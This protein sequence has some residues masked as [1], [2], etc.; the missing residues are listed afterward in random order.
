[1]ET[2]EL[3]E[4]FPLFTVAE[5]ETLEWLLS[6]ADECEFSAGTTL[7][8]DGSWGTAV[9]FI[10]SGWLRMQRKHG[11][12]AIT[13][14]VLGRGDFIGDAAILD[15]PPRATEAIALTDV[16]TLGVSAQRFIQALFK[17]PQL[18]HK[19][20]QHVVRR[21]RQAHTLLSLRHQP[22]LVR[23][24][25]TIV[26]I[27][28]EYGTP[29]EEGMEIVNL[30]ARDWADLS[31]IGVD[32]VANLLAKWQGKGWL[33]LGDRIMCVTNLKQLEHLTGGL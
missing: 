29:T 3:S 24:A 7:L 25:W 1:M 17:D 15:E 6:V 11:D 33:E 12:R 14:A 19:L 20:L 21:W 23:L 10:E 16:R 31:G 27:A 2:T 9:Y 28:E 5:P 30:P 22:V 13:Q 26:T 18:H 32:D 8:T 4:L